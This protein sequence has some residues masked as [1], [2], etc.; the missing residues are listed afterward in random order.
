MMTNNVEF[1]VQFNVMLSWSEN[2]MLLIIS[3]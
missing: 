2:K 3:C 1:Y